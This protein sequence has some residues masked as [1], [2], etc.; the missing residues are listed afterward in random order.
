MAYRYQ[1]NIDAIEGYP[2]HPELTTLEN[3]VSKVHWALEVRWVEDGSVHYL[4]GSTDIGTPNPDLFTDHLE[5][6][7]ED[8]LGFV[9]AVIGGRE[10]AETIARNELAELMSPSRHKVQSLG[11]PWNADCCPDGEG[12]DQAGLAATLGN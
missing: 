11:M 9:W 2:E 7:N 8:V 4:R 1:W 10:E 12:I 3:V 5:L 6:S